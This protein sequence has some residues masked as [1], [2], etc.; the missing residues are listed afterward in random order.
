MDL[1]S[2]A[3]STLLGGV[4]GSVFR[5]VPEVLK[6]FTSKRDQDHEY[7][8][9]R[10][11]GDLAKD[12]SEQ[13]IREAEAAGNMVMDAKGMDALIAAIQGQ[14]QATGNPIADAISATLR[15]V[16]TYWW[17][18]LY[19]AVKVSLLIVR[20]NALGAAESVISIWGPEDMAILS[21]IINFWFL[22]RVIR[23]RT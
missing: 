22:D 6:L 20:W 3:A 15:P 12:G 18:F 14:S 1:L 5:L 11:Q 13:R 10:L 21:G 7:R 17:M 16:L 19:S 9:A 23:K 2:G 4:F 8:M